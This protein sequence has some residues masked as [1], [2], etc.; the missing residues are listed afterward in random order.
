MSANDPATNSLINAISYVAK[1][2][3]KFSPEYVLDTIKAY[4]HRYHKGQF[5]TETDA[6]Q[7]LEDFNKELDHYEGDPI[8]N[9]ETIARVSRMNG[10]SELS[11]HGLFQAWCIMTEIARIEGTEER[12]PEND[13]NWAYDFP[14]FA[15]W[16]VNGYEPTEGDD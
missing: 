15:G 16:F 5:P 3:R 6:P 1:N 9:P 13:H 10:I 8:P 12:Y 2:E 7:V 11:A 4:I 14:V